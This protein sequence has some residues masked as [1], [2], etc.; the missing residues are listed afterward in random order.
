M[1]LFANLMSP[2]LGAVPS[3]FGYV[4]PLKILGVVLL[5][6]GWAAVA[7]W[8]DRDTDAVKTKR[9]QWN[10]IVLA[11]SAVGFFVLLFVPI[12][13]GALFFLGIGFWLLI[14]GGGEGKTVLFGSVGS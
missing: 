9:E 11:G 14:T 8:I 4:N 10:L 2:I 12:W 6:F 3:N 1:Y 5:T 7:Q 13:H